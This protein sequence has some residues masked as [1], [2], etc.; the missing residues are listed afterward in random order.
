MASR[1]VFHKKSM[2]APGE[3]THHIKVRS[4]QLEMPDG[5][6]SNR[7]DD[8]DHKLRAAQEELERIQQQREELERKKRELEELTERKRTFIGQQVEMSEK[9]SAALTNIDRELFAI[10]QEAEDLEQCRV[11]FAAHLDKLQKIVPENWPSESLSDKL[12]R[13]TMALDL[14]SDE[15]D[16]AAAHFEG[17]RSGAI[18]GRPGKVG[19]SRSRFGRGDTEFAVQLRNGVAFNLPLILLGSLALLVYLLK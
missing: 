16:Q 17:S 10:R 14:A 2:P 8:Y 19:R 1:P 9:L 11:C 13:A 4:S 18:F 7:G 15:F 6:F 12:E 3:H 5:T